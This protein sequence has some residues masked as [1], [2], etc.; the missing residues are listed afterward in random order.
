MLGLGLCVVSFGSWWFA[1]CCGV[2]AAFKLTGLLLWPVAFWWGIGHSKLRHFFAVCMMGGVWSVLTP[3]SLLVGG[4][5]LLVAQVLFR[6]TTYAGQS[7]EYGGP[8]G[9]FLPTRYLW[10]FELAIIL[11]AIMLLPS[12]FINLVSPEHRPHP[13]KSFPDSPKLVSKPLDKGI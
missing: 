5:P 10:P 1:I 9:F 6:L 11:S 4:V 3:V 13:K 2:T 7:A 8:G 12:L